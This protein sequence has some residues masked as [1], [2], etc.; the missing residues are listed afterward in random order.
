MFLLCLQIIAQ[1]V[2]LFVET[3][4][5]EKAVAVY[6]CN[7]AHICNRKLNGKACGQTHPPIVTPGW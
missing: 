5:R 6:E 2:E 7:L 4:T 3:L 1:M